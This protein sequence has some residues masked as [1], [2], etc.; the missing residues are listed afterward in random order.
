MKRQASDRAD[1][2]SLREL[3]VAAK[4]PLLAPEPRSTPLSFR[5]S[6][7]R[8][9][10]EL[11]IRPQ[12]AG[13]DVASLNDGALLLFVIGELSNRLNTGQDLSSELVV[14]PNTILRTLGR[15]SGGSQYESLV[16]A[17]RRLAN[18]LVSTNLVAGAERHPH[19]FCLLEAVILT[20]ESTRAPW[21]LRVPEWILEQV[22]RRRFLKVAPAA[23]RLHGLERRL[24]SWAHAH[25]G[26]RGY[27]TYPVSFAEARSKAGSTDLPRR[28][29]YSMR[30]ALKRIAA[31]DRIPGFTLVEED[32]RGAPGLVIRRGSTAGDGA[33]VGKEE[34]F[35]GQDQDV[36]TIDLGE[37]VPAI[38]H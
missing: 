1:A 32:F 35:S 37:V 14:A 13:I 4:Y 20:P 8:I 25:A 38:D 3:L 9:P 31:E 27:D 21:R 16:A 24:Y 34:N 23:L 5:G 36:E 10:F 30:R 17:A 18:T 15:P 22:R 2:A 19:T 29:A 6:E 33:R 11:T 28:F 26:G 12:H 7:A